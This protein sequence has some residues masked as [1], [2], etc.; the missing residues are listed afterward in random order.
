MTVVD[1]DSIL[2]VGLIGRTAVNAL[3]V[4]FALG[5]VGAAAVVVITFIEDLQEVF[6]K[7]YPRR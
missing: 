1:V 2:A 3:E 6:S 5:F 4:L 7:H